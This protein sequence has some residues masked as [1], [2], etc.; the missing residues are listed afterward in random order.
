MNVTPPT[1]ATAPGTHIWKLK[2]PALLTGVDPSNAA[3]LRS[4]SVRRS[5]PVRC[6]SD[7]GPA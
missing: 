2:M 4:S 5:N 3:R 1:A 7:G 6:R